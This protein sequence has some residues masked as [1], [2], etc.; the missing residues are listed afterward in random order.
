MALKWSGFYRFFYE[1][2][3][4]VTIALSSNWHYC[5]SNDPGIASYKRNEK[6]NLHRAQ[7]VTRHDVMEPNI[8]DSIS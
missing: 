6:T 7:D 1:F 8:E 4:I 5:N 2:N 3:T